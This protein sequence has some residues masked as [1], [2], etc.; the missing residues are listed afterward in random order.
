MRFVVF[1]ATSCREIIGEPLQ[2]FRGLTMTHLLGFV[3]AVLIF[4]LMPTHLSAEQSSE[5]KPPLTLSA[6]QIENYQLRYSQKSD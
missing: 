1:H 3:V 5:A 2:N 4:S 6:E